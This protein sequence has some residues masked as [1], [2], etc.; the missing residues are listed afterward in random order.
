MTVMVVEQIPA[1]VHQVPPLTTCSSGYNCT[2]GPSLT[3]CRPTDNTSHLIMCL[4]HLTLEDHPLLHPPHVNRTTPLVLL[5]SSLWYLIPPRPLNHTISVVEVTEGL[6]I[7]LPSRDSASVCEIVVPLYCLRFGLS[8]Y[9]K[10]NSCC[11]YDYTHV[12]LWAFK[13]QT[14]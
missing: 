10:P 7:R 4:T 14:M 9:A 2:T 3:T 11:R 13:C 1:T 6:L 8:I 12:Q 5:D